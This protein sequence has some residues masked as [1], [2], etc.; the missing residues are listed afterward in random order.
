MGSGS[1][2]KVPREHFALSEEEEEL[3]QTWGKLVARKIRAYSKAM[4]L[5][6][7]EKHTVY[8]QLMGLMT[9]FARMQQHPGLDKP[10][11]LTDDDEANSRPLLD[12]ESLLAEVEDGKKWPLE[13]CSRFKA[14]IGSLGKEYADR[15]HVI[16]FSKFSDSLELLAIYL[17]KHLP[18]RVVYKYYGTDKTLENQF[19]Q[20]GGVLLMT[21]GS[22]GA[23][24]N[25]PECQTIVNPET[26]Q[27]EKHAMLIM[28]ISCPESAREKAQADGRS[29]RPAIQGEGTIHTSVTFFSTNGDGNDVIGYD[30]YAK[31]S[32]DQK[33]ISSSM[34]E[35]GG[36]EGEENVSVQQTSALRAF[37]DKLDPLACSE[38][39]SVAEEEEQGIETPEEDADVV[40]AEGKAEAKAEG[41][42]RRRLKKKVD[43]EGEPQACL[44]PVPMDEGSD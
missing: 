9:M 16:I 4:Y 12:F 20:E 31:T 3:L 35:E 33:C 6:E 40:L 1:E 25:F 42:V 14:I 38:R 21:Y 29:D 23:G 5:Q 17:R 2:K 30:L 11:Q 26:G 13:R 34:Y 7:K 36:K 18:E 43:N 15:K 28:H 27:A 44:V 37:A 19:R 41:K 24:I 10:K 39:H 32:Y 8:M 22:G